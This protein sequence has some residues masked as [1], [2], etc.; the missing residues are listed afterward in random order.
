MLPLLF[1]LVAGAR[2]RWFLTWSKV[3]IVASRRL[4]QVTPRIP[5]L[6]AEDQ[7]THSYRITEFQ[8]E[9]GS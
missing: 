6:T 9:K 2:V 1:G 5:E 7:E 4:P 8:T 3:R